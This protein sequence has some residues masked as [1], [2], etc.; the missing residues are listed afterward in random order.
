MDK[1]LVNMAA[2]ATLSALLVIFGASTFFDIVYPKGGG[3]EPEP[4][5]AALDHG[6][7]GGP[8]P[9]A[10]PEVPLP[11]L[12][13]AASVEAGQSEFKKC[14]ACH[15]AEQGGPNRV[16]PNLHG[17]VGNK[18]ASHADFAYSPQ[19]V[20]FGGEW[21]YERLDCFIENP[22]G[23][24]PGTKMSFAGVK[25]DTARANVIA[26][27]RSISPNA[28]PLPEPAQAAS[29][30]PASDAPEAEQQNA[31]TTDAPADAPSDAPAPATPQQTAPAAAAPN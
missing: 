28:P 21:T 11:D 9:T 23:C 7:T 14:T 1:W 4:E 27:L 12:L 2:G 31:R 19:L 5:H 6:G 26:Y 20:E 22:K 8:T 30:E 29:A 24:V 17:V 3:P 10:E 16:G 25:S 13:A 18:V 15:T